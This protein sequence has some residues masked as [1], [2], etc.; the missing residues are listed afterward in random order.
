MY[1][2]LHNFLNVLAQ[3]ANEIRLHKEVS[4]WN[5][6]S[7]RVFTDMGLGIMQFGRRL[8]GIHSAELQGRK[9]GRELKM[10]DKKGLKTEWRVERKKEKKIL[11]YTCGKQE[12][13]QASN[14]TKSTYRTHLQNLP[15]EAAYPTKR[16]F[17]CVQSCV[18]FLKAS[19][20]SLEH[21]GI[22]RNLSLEQGVPH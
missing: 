16:T 4:N 12:R 9:L 14:N 13:T 7:R 19:F 18:E 11:H 20:N 6:Y 21:K 5:T 22:P 2:F 3:I 15:K 8:E 10:K 1:T 17:K